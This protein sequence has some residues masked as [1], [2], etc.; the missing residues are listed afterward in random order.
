MHVIAL[1]AYT[2]NKGTGENAYAPVVYY[3]RK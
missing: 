3:N 1:Q 2:D